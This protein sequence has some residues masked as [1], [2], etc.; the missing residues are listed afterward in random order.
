MK[1]LLGVHSSFLPI[2]LVLFIFVLSACKGSGSNG[3]YTSLRE[4]DSARDLSLY[5]IS[6]S[7]YTRTVKP[8]GLERK[9]CRQPY[10]EWYC[11][12]GQR[13]EHQS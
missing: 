2:I 11:N 3:N 9:K 10:I 1:T 6:L 7:H 5:C 12:H 13:Y 4:P 8:I